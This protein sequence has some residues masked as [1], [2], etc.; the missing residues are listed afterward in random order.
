MSAITFYNNTPGLS[1]KN[2]LEEKRLEAEKPVRMLLQSYKQEVWR[3]EFGCGSE[4]ND[5]KA[6]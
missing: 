1:G 2:G 5:K 3:P 4:E 6:I